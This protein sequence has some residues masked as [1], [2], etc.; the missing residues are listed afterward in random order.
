MAAAARVRTHRAAAETVI[1]RSIAVF[2]IAVS[3]RAVGDLVV[4]MPST[5]LWWGIVFGGGIA[6]SLT[7]ILA[8]AIRGSLARSAMGSF[9]ALVAVGLTLWPL[10]HPGPETGP[11]WL[12]H[13]LMLGTTCLAGATGPW[14]ASMYAIATATMFALVRATPSGGAAWAEVAV[15]DAAYAAIVGI[16]L[17]V[18]IQAMRLGARQSDSAEEE[19]VEAYQE[20]ASAR[21]DLAERHRLAALLHDTVMTALVLVARTGRAATLAERSSASKAAAEGLRQLEGYAVGQ[22]AVDPVPA[23]E[24]P[25][26]LQTISENTAFLPVDIYSQVPPDADVIV[27]GIVA[28]AIIEATYTAVDN[29]SRHSGANA[30][31]INVSLLAA[32]GRLRVEIADNG[33]G[34]DP[35]GVSQRRLGIRLSMV[36][37]M[38]DVGG[39]ASV[40]SAP[41]QGTRIILEWNTGHD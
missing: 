23:S 38:S 40:V 6:F 22:L 25:A 27:P 26:R 14:T 2:A 34:F 3:A 13:F 33:R 30:V 21:A 8:A 36:Q 31:R 9:A 10:G 12:W 5:A 29:A 17:S 15:Q 24:I 41:G 16:A 11:P 18:A 19:A 4:E 39:V 37:R 35:D 7:V 1:A 20:S 28:S 32:P